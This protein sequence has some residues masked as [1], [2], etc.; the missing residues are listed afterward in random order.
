MPSPHCSWASAPFARAVIT[1]LAISTYSTFERI[2]VAE[3]RTCGRLGPKRQQLLDA[4]RLQQA[5]PYRDKRSHLQA[6]K[7]PC[8][9][10]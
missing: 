5:A 3:R 2:A 10:A 4:G 6:Y 9:T 7:G 8:S 1:S